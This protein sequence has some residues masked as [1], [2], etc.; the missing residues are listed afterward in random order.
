MVL[1]NPLIDVGSK[2]VYT[3]PKSICPKVNL[4]A[5]L[6]SEIAYHIVKVQFVKGIPLTIYDLICFGFEVYQPLEVI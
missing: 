5:R 2:W 3:F 4:F 1:F 6:E